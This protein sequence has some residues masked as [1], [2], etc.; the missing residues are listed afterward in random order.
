[1]EIDGIVPDYINPDG[2]KDI[3]GDVVYYRDAEHHY[4]VEVKIGTIRLTKRE[5]NRWVAST[6]RS[7]WPN[8]FIGICASGMAIC[9]WAEFRSSYIASI[10]AKNPAWRPGIL[11]KGYGPMKQ[12][13]VL[14]A[15]LSKGAWFP[16]VEAHL[17]DDYEKRFR[18]RL[19][20]YRS[21][22]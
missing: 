8:L 5:F 12:V 19:K 6:D 20:T 4:G 7:A 22:A 13:N 2:T 18:K 1:M 17:A 3:L 21:A 10:K 15:Y 9:P 11:R 16:A 14:A